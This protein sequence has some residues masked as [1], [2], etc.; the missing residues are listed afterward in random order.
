MEWLVEILRDNPVIPIFLTIGIG[1]W[2]GGLKIKSFSLGPVTATLIV[3][4]LIGQLD[5]PVSDTLKN[6]SF[7]LFLFAIGY[8]VGPQFFRS[9]KGDGLKQ[10]GFALVEVA[11]CIITVVAV[12]LIMGY[13]KGMAVGLFSGS[14]AFSAVIGVGSSTIKSLGLPPAEQQAYLDIIPACYAVCYVFGT[15][16][17]AWVIANLGPMLLGGLKKVKAQT[18]QLEAEMDSG[19]ITPDPGTFVANRPISFR[20]YRAESDYFSHPRSVE[21]IENHIRVLGLRHFIERLRIKGEITD[22]EP[23]LKVRKGDIIVLS[24]RRETIVDDAGWIGPE[25]TDH[26]LLNF[27]A[28]YLPVTVSKAGA[29]GITIGE[30]R[31]QDYMRGVMI[32]KILRDDVRIPVKS[33]TRLESG[34]VVTLVGLPQDVATAVSQIGYSDRPSEVTDMTFTGLGIAI[35]CFIG[36]LTVHF[37]GIPVSL[38]TS[39][40]AILAGLIL[41]WLR[42]KRPTFG[43]IPAPVLW[44]MNNFG[45]N[46]FIAVV[47][48]AAGPTFISGL[49]QVGVEMFLVG[50]VCTSVPLILSIIIGAKLFKFPPALT[51]G[52]AAG[53]RNAVAALGAI[54]DNLESTLPAM[55]YTVTYAVGSIT[56]ILAGMIVPL[57]V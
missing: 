38:S 33:R 43:R 49:K 55:S 8:S 9:L 54:Q 21:D 51:L 5:I 6:V 17:S 30:L 15:I 53:S 41:G 48:L 4:V 32:H 44:F 18:A 11:L 37:K 2:L 23:E 12:S 29:D 40:G 13:N 35:G 7:M 34:D 24:G 52:C 45:L 25:V 3:G 56:L 28:E 1:F 47:G 20:A 10:I 19:D 46:M 57:I 16:G 31:R 36:A 50:I 26:E 14:Q 39:G 27:A 22:P 42:N